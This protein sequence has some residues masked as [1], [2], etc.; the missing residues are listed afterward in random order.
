M[1]RA[2]C[3]VLLL[4]IGMSDQLLA[5]EAVDSKTKVE[6]TRK[7]ELNGKE[8]YSHVYLDEEVYH[9]AAEDLRDLRVIDDKGQEVPYYLYNEEINATYAKEVY[10]AKVLDS[11]V[12]RDRDFFD[13]AV[14]QEENVD[15]WLSYLAFEVDKANF[16][17]E[18]TIQG[19]Y[20][21]VKWEKVNEGEA[22][23]V[24]DVATDSH[25]ALH[26]A[27]PVKY[28][29]FRLSMP[30]Q[31]KPISITKVEAVFEKTDYTEQPY[32]RVKKSS[33]QINEDSERKTTIVTIDNSDHLR[34]SR[35]GVSINGLF[36]RKYMLIGI[37]DEGYEESLADGNMH[38]DGLEDEACQIEIRFRPSARYRAYKLKIYNLDDR[39]LEIKGIE[40]VY[41]IDK[42][43][44]KTEPESTYTLVYGDHTLALPQYDIAYYKG[45]IEKEIQ[46][47]GLL[48]EVQIKEE[49]IE[50]Q[51]K[52]KDFKLVFEVLIAM[53]SV[54]LIIVILSANKKRIIQK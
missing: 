21:G 30:S 19:S 14:E 47:E 17:S 53:T 39:P 26:F 51:K 43:V 2:I 20:D 50:E 15:R 11:Y 28:C 6:V 13:I 44:F 49:V 25:M 33:Y 42:L 45:D 1:R 16:A 41:G 31:T 40:D 48:R 37:D 36:N 52:E 12:D 5:S 4:M 46:N 54:I 29:F 38:N 10:G 7:I 9:Y 23:A 34:I 3:L 8:T 35:F 18:V 22:I 24:Y 27:E 32:L